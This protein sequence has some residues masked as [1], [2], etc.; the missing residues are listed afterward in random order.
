MDQQNQDQAQTAAEAPDMA[1]LFD[2]QM[3]DALAQ[4]RT[5]ING[6]AQQGIPFP[7]V[8]TAMMVSLAGSI[9]TV[10]VMSGISHDEAQAQLADGSEKMKVML[11]KIFTE[12]EQQ[13]AEAQPTEDQPGW[14]FPSNL[15]SNGL[16]SDK[17]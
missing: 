8:A 13:Q 5:T 10:A 2:Y 14:M 16:S 15:P 4:F 7:I 1:K 17:Q 12:V 9:A 11:A 6:M 3:N